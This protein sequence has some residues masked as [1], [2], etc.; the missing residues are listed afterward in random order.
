[1]AGALLGTEA[2]AFGQMSPGPLSRAH[3]DLDGALNCAKCHAFG[4]GKVEMR[5]VECHQEIA[6]RLEA[7][8]GYH[9]LQV[10]PGTQSND[11]ARC[12]SEHNGLDHML[13]RWPGSKEHFDHEQAGLR[14]EGRHGQL[15]CAECH[16]TKYM[17]PRDKAV[18][19]RRNLAASFAGLTARCTACHADAHG[20]QLG[21]SC[22]DCHSQETW[23]NPPRFSHA[24]SRFPL[25]GR[26]EQVQCAACHKPRPDATPAAVPYRD[27][28]RFEECLACHK[29]PHGNAFGQVCEK[30]HTTSGWK[31]MASG[32]AFDHSRTRY[33]LIGKHI[34]VTCDKCHKPG[35]LAVNPVFNLCSDC[36]QDPHK[37]QFTAGWAE[38]D[39][40]AC[41]DESGF[42][43]TSFGVAQ[44][45]QSRFPLA[46]KHAAVACGK[47]HAPRGE[48]TE[49]LV[50]F[51]A[52]GDCH[53]DA[54]QRQFAAAPHRDR[55]EDCHVADGWRPSTFEMAAHQETRFSLTGAHRAVP[56]AACHMPEGPNAKYHPDG[57]H[58]ENCHKT[59]HGE[60][61]TAATC[62]SC[63]KTQ[64]WTQIAFFDHS[65]ARFAL[66]G[67][68]AAVQCLACHKPEDRAGLRFIP[69]A[70]VASRCETC[71][72]DIHDGQFR[73]KDNEVAC[74]A[75]HTTGDWRPTEFDHNRH[76][77]FKLDGA[78]QD[79]PCRLCHDKRREVAGRLVIEYK[80]T[81]RE[82]D[83]CHL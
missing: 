67:R 46:G 65:Q 66:T 31:T 74:A 20:G 29:D 8:R 39:C 61:A 32:Q 52:C 50:K 41:H 10:K 76:S 5:C 37:G 57:G 58:C 25:T 22:L 2:V 79:V 26:H 60:R 75:C 77:T 43:K 13:V 38:A 49:F 17:D 81:P 12:H 24:R 71:H 4:T 33:P 80:G 40:K 63:H 18:L 83:A 53:Q 11:C 48:Q 45:T 78:H 69:L 7:K 28:V 55:C 47:C 30:C 14:L 35:Q 73:T 54:H 1:M 9:A 16:N 21:A 19:K 70:G 3:R 62:E 34:A 44:H 72:T 23:K 42:K 56:C 82:C 51:A 59:P 36:H 6:R 27:F 64:A 15:K 68:H